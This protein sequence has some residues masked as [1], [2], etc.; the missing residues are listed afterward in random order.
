MEPLLDLKLNTEDPVFSNEYARKI[1]Y[2]TH[3]GKIRVPRRK[4]SVVEEYHKIASS[5]NS[6][7][8]VLSTVDA[9]Y[10]ELDQ[11]HEPLSFFS[12]FQSLTTSQFY[13]LH[14][15]LPYEL[16]MDLAHFQDHDDPKLEKAI[17][18]VPW[19]NS[20]AKM[21]TVYNGLLAV[22]MSR[23]DKIK[24]LAEHSE[25][26]SRIPQELQQCRSQIEAF[27]SSLETHL[28]GYRSNAILNEELQKRIMSEVGGFEKSSRADIHR[29]I[30]IT[31][32]VLQDFRAFKEPLN[33]QTEEGPQRKRKRKKRSIDDAIEQVLS[34]T[35]DTNILSQEEGAAPLIQE[36]GAEPLIQE[37]VVL[38]REV[39][40][41]ETTFVI[42]GLGIAA[43][44][45]L[46]A[47]TR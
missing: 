3:I 47:I 38:R 13:H 10:L 46:V 23:A 21:V 41:S 40:G 8:A 35:S 30:V 28:G 4:A 2:E 43:F 39:K 33:K 31:S 9:R 17:E 22:Y 44:L 25:R 11:R 34:S 27:G 26:Y 18:N 15:V 7:S 6:L 5:F 1:L 45:G 24:E 12:S 20:L 42:A 14:D 19:Y 16:Q 32:K 37:E 36:K 29:A